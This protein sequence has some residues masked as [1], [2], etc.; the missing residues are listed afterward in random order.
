MM[1]DFDIWVAFF[2][3]GLMGCLLCARIVYR[4]WKVLRDEKKEE[5]GE[6]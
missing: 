5:G 4:M 3:I 2:V 6:K 1:Q